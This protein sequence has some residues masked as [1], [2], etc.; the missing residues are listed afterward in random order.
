MRKLAHASPLD[1]TAIVNSGVKNCDV[2][3]QDVARAV[4]IYGPSI[5]ALKGKTTK[6]QTAS[7][8]QEF[9]QR[10]VQEHQ[11]MAVDIMFFMGVAVFIAALNPLGLTLVH[12]LPGV[13]DRPTVGAKSSKVIKAGLVL[14]IGKA[15]RR[16][17]AIEVISTASA[18]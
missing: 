9:S 16:N 5:A 2:T 18:V 3:V 15:K 8:S 6:T 11:V 10:M 13:S 17:F 1:T 7:D 12:H 4:A 14:F